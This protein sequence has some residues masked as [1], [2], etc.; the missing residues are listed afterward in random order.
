MMDFSA[1][2]PLCII[3]ARG[4]SKRLPRKNILS[5]GGKPLLAW[6]IEAAKNAGL[7]DSLWVSSEDEEIL[8]TALRFGA[9]PLVRPASLA[10]DHVTVVELCIH[11][12]E[13]FEFLEKGYTDMY[14]ML[15]TSPFRSS[16]TIKRAWRAYLEKGADAL[17][18]IV[19][20]A[21]PPQ[22]ALM[23]ADGRLSPLY[24][25]QYETPRQGLVSA[26]RHDGGHAIGKIPR[27][28]RTRSFFGPGTIAFPVP[29]EEAVDVD[30]PID[31]A[32]AEFLLQRSEGKS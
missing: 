10:T 7:F 6:T 29:E 28:I 12:I 2:K 11:L 9:T 23:E 20:L 14:V 1:R 15:P 24:P 8:E 17:M 30:E 4:G 13:E 31:L 5:L 26:Y 18:S 27:F 16:E 25:E 19:A 22:W 32:W 21:H 3:P